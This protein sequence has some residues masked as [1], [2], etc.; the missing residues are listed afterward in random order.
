MSTKRLSVFVF[1]F[2]VLYFSAIDH[3]PARRRSINSF[4][5]TES[6]PTVSG[7]FGC[8]T[9]NVWSHSGSSSICSNHRSD[10]SDSTSSSNADDGQS[11]LPNQNPNR[12]S[13]D[14]LPDHY[15]PLTQ[16]FLLEWPP[17]KGRSQ[18]M[19]FGHSSA[20]RVFP[21]HCFGEPIWKDRSRCW[22]EE[23]RSHDTTQSTSF[24]PIPLTW[25]KRT[26]W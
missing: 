14:P 19:V 2:S 17:R 23:L 22:F 15:R 26:L 11:F 16:S 24:N 9:C 5:R 1:F 4:H 21:V 20:I 25:M 18:S 10:R 6:S 13:R 3:L 12:M 7:V 8:F